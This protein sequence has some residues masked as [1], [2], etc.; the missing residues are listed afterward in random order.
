[1][2]ASPTPRLLIGFA[3][4]LLAVSLY[5]WFTLRQVSSLRTLQSDIVERNRRDSL[6]LLRIQDTLNSLGFALHDVLETP[7]GITGFETQFRR[8]RMQL[9]D[10]ITREASLAPYAEQD[11][12]QEQLAAQLQELDATTDRTFERARAGDQKQAVALIK[13]T[14]RPQRDAL[15]ARIARML[16]QNS[17][18]DRQTAQQI[19]RIYDRVERDLYTFLL[20][21]AVTIGVTGIA[22]FYSNRRIFRQLATLSDQKSV[23]ARKLITVQEEVLRSVSRE[24]HDEFGQIFTAIGAMLSRLERKGVPPD[25]PLRADL[26]E[27]REITQGSLEKVRTLS[28]MLHPAVIDDYGLEKAIEWYVPTFEKQTG[29]PVS[30]QKNGTGPALK[31]EAAIHVYR[32]LQEALN[33]VARHSGAKQATV[34]VRYAPDLLRLEVEDSGKG[35]TAKAADERTGL[36]MVAM[37]ERAEL[38][39]GKLKLENAPNG[40]TI[41]SLEVPTNHDS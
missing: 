41:V 39:H 34:R 19:T 4:T 28:Q 10:A 31:N 1:M 9:R 5:S 25:S 27:I 6:Q 13:G 35:F 7:Y 16:V 37:R 2:K 40:G 29:I 22:L 36:G 21:T 3:V 24:L 32:I 23:L 38:V 30:Y 17:E 12:D 18:L 14:L 33:N 26:L 15:A 11:A 8:L 20:A